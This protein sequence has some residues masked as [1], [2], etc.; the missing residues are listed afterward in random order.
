MMMF[1]ANVTNFALMTDHFKRHWG[2]QDVYMWCWFVA[3]TNN[4][5]DKKQNKD[6]YWLYAQANWGHR[7]SPVW[8]VTFRRILLFA[9]ITVC[10][11]VCNEGDVVQLSAPYITLCDFSISI[12]SRNLSVLH[13][14]YIVFH[15]MCKMWEMFRLYLF[16]TFKNVR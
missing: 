5:D 16:P 11:C 13:F 15:S 1:T 2:K 7:S 3:C 4:K 9:V 10:E 6:D 12:I 14:S 8:C